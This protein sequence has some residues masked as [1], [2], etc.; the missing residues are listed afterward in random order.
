MI[1]ARAFKI[2]KETVR[3]LRFPFSIYL[4]PVF[5]FSLSQVYVVHWPSAFLIFFVLHV[6]VYPSSNGFNS[7]MD[8][9]TTSIGGLEKPPLP[10]ADLYVVTLM[11]DFVAVILSLWINVQTAVFV[12]LYILASRAYSERRI[13]LKK[14]PWTGFAV[15]SA[16]QGGVTF[17]IVF[18]AVNQTGL[19]NALTTHVFLGML[20]S[21][22]IIGASYPLTQIYQHE[23]DKKNGDITLSIKLGYA[24]TFIFSASLFLMALVVLFVF[25]HLLENPWMFYMFMVFTLP[26][27]IFFLWWFFRVSKDH[28]QANFKNTMRMNTISAGSMALYFIILII[29]NFST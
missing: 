28:R 13:R 25:F 12:A 19:T 23:A 1:T 10:T 29:Y 16:F 27:I 7:Y 24:G 3:L 26:V 5:L 17:L 22:L 11:M 20:A 4:A 2:S 6:L 9:D 14:Y 18:L 21:S 8:R 15:V